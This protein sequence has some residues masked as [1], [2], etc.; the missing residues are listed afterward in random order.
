MR[1]ASTKGGGA[2]AEA[3]LWVTLNLLDIGLSLTAI[4]VGAVEVNLAVRALGMGPWAFITYK[5][6]M[7]VIV[8]AFLAHAG[9]AHLLRWLN[10]AMGGICL[11]NA[12]VILWSGLCQGV[13]LGVLG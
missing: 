7:A 6:A 2:S 4:Y 5:V 9:K 10:T 8:V 1:I 3:G 12:L 13:L 11:W